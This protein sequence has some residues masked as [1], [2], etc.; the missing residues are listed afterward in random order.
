MTTAALVEGAAGEA[1]PGPRAEG[2]GSDAEAGNR[3]R[4]FHRAPTRA[5]LG[6]QRT[7][8]HGTGSESP[9]SPVLS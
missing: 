1:E 2:E 9:R 8:G 6:T 7:Q 4:A 5:P 3:P